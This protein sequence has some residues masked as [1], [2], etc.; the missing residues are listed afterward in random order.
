MTCLALIAA[1]WAILHYV[2]IAKFIDRTFVPP[3]ETQEIDTFY[4][5]L[6]D[7][8]KPG[9]SLVANLNL[10]ETDDLS[11][12]MK[13]LQDA[14]GLDNYSIELAYHNKEKPPGYIHIEENSNMLRNKMTIYLSTHLKSRREQITVLIHELGHIYVWTLPKY[15][16]GAFDQEKLVDTSGMFLG[17]GVLTL[18]GMSDE[19]KQTPEGGY[20]TSQKTFGYLKPE[21]F[22]YLLARFCRDRGI[23]EKEVKPHLNS[24]GWKYFK[25]G[26]AHFKKKAQ[27]VHVPELVQKAQSEIRKILDFFHEKI[28]EIFAR[29]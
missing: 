5:L 7:T 17:L 26:N 12:A 4:D 25:I 8:Q 16:F 13:K 1:A 22:G 2:D 29:F 14:M 23:T 28:A 9:K 20:Q 11:V 19:F 3:V 18:N 10:K 21:E 27:G 24:A 6:S 15:T